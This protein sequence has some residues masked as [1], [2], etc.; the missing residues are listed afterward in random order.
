MEISHHVYLCWRWAGSI[1]K[2][3]PPRSS[4]KSLYADLTYVSYIFHFENRNVHESSQT[5]MA[6]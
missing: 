1:L 4:D 3:E 5:S 2:G 6:M